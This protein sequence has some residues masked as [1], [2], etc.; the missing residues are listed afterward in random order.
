VWHA[1]FA[2]L[3]HVAGDV[4]IEVE[5]GL[6]ASIREGVPAARNAKR[7]RGLTIPG[8]AN[9]HSHAFQR[10]LRA[11]TQHGAGDFWTWRKLMY[12]EAARLDPDSYFEL[13][14]GVY[15]EMAQAGITVVGEFH[16]LHHGPGGRPYD[17]PNAMGEALIAAAREAGIRITLIDAC[18]LWSGIGKGALDGVQLRFGDGDA[19]RWAAR[20]ERL[21]PGSDVRIAAAAHSV[22]AVDVAGIVA[23]A[24]WAKRSRAP[25]HVHLSEQPS[26][27]EECRAAT[28]VTPTRLLADAGAL[29][30][31]TTAVHATHV[32]S[33]DIALLGDARAA[34]CL[35]PTTERDLGDGVGPG[36]ALAAAGARL[37]VGTDSHAMIDVFEEARAV[38][39]DQRLVTNRRGHHS[40]E[41][42][43]E[44]ATGAGYVALGWEGGRIEA[45]CLADF[46]TLDLA[47]PRLA[48]LPTNE[49]AAGVVFAATASDV[50]T[51]VVGGRTII[52]G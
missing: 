3:G 4:A 50:R 42:L 46:I 52:G 31:S 7:L 34:V 13:A 29:S 21:R 14:R 19:E 1:D 24:G 41:G 39:L 22:R 28:G 44:A 17:D 26:E 2:W 16:Y 45:G 33:S 51:V 38:E 20:V 36:A 18:Y 35:C 47:S 6:I 49:L 37:C 43:L 10:T 32:D 8:L 15:R 12:E 23:V 9:V 11:R 25:F 48:G 30:P 5:D 40:P 27:N